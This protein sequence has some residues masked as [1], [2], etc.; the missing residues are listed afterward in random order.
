MKRTWKAL[1]A[2]PILA[3][4]AAVV[5]WTY[6]QNPG[7]DLEH[8]FRNPPDSAWPRTW[9][10]WTGGNVTKEGI[11]KD[12]EWM[13]R[14]GIAGMQL[15]DVSSGRG[16]TTEKKIE[17]GSPER[18][19]ALR[20]AASESRRLG[21]EMALFSSP[22]WSETGGPWVKPEQAMKKLVWSETIVEGPRKFEGKLPQ[23]P[24][25][26]F[27][28]NIA[29]ASLRIGVDPNAPKEL[30]AKL[31]ELGA[32][33]REV[34]PRPT[35]AGMGGGALGVEGAAAFDEYVRRKAKETG[36]DLAN[37]PEPAGR[38]SGGGGRGGAAGEGARGGPG[39]PPANPMRRP[40]GIPAS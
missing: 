6:A 33:P 3:G 30:V 23:P 26:N 17:F 13:K 38:G 31:R 16:Q 15:A 4:L 10:H 40:T 24:S 7:N 35:V 20:H 37:L 18:M 29:L 9:W 27:D 8:G 39:G 14:V 32:K 1:I 25:N 36:L 22:G 12:L 28:R 21:L 34:G 5:H 19:D 2:V 11:T